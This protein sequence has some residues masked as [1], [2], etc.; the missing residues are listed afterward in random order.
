MG[1]KNAGLFAAAL[2]QAGFAITSGLALGIDGACHHGALSAGGI[3]IGV[4]GTGLNWPYPRAHASLIDQ[5]VQNRGAVVSE[6]PLNMQA[7]PNHFP[8]RN[9]IISGL[10]LGALVIEAALKS[11]SLIT[12]RHALEQGREVFAIPGPIHNPLAKGCHYLL[13]QGAKLVETV[14]DILSEF[15][16]TI[17]NALSRTEGPCSSRMTT[18]SLPAPTALTPVEQHVLLQIAYEST[19]MDMILCRSGLTPG[20]LSSILL[21]LELS[22]HIQSVAGGYVKTIAK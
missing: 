16:E 7:H 10:S 6:F 3:T 9:R 5:I 8:R 1:L 18:T 17:L 22:G 2:V 11:G 15:G 12:A 14:E 19:H 13:R 4:S 20:E 21:N